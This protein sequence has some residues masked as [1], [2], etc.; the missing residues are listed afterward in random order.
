MARGAAT[1]RIHAPYRH[2]GP[3]RQLGEV[4]IGRACCCTALAF[5]RRQNAQYVTLFT[6][7]C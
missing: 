6:K 4:G 5:F 2:T 1:R 3:A 7:I